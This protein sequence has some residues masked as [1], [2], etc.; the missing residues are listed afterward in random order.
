MIT[1]LR[2][3]FKKKEERVLTEEEKLIDIINKTG[4]CP[5]CGGILL[6]LLQGPSGGCS[7]N[8]MCHMCKNK[9]NIAIGPFGIFSVERI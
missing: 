5:D 7:V 2:N 6:I 4:R 8:V 9:F 1:W 3:I